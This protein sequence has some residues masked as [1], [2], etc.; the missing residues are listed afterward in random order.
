MTPLCRFTQEVIFL[1][2]PHHANPPVADFTVFV[3]GWE[4]FFVLSV[5][6]TQCE[7]TYTI[8]I[9]GSSTIFRGLV[10]RAV[11]RQQS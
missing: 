8:G 1:Q 9:C 7:G 5:F 3:F 2:S 11:S 6:R 4:E 10:A